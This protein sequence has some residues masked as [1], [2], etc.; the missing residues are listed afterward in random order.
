M[1]LI[2]RNLILDRPLAV[3]DLESTGID[4]RE[5]R[6]VEV[7]VLKAGPCTGPQRFYH[8]LNPGRPIPPLATLVHG[9]TDGDVATAPSFATIARDLFKFVEG[10]DLAGF[11]ISRF[12]LPL[13]AAEFGRVGLRFSVLGRAVIDALDVYHRH[14][15]RN[16]ST[17]VEY[18]LGRSHSAAHSAE[19]DAGAALAVLDAQVERYELPR[20]PTELHSQLVAVDVAGRFR[21]DAVG[22]VVFGFGKYLGQ[23]LKDLAVRNPGYLQWMLKE[24]FLDDV[25]ALVRIALNSVG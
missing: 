22:Q 20:T 23:R 18:Y 16:L 24:A 12:D 8:R 5:D 14:E 4:I 2:V 3:L 25:H 10:C 7:A 6:I 9:I 17:A 13:L 21:R 11:G 19:A 1:T 15:L